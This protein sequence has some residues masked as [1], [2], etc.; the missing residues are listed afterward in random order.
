MKNLFIIF[1]F[2]SFCITTQAQNTEVVQKA[3][4]SGNASALTGQ[5]A[6]EIELCIGNDVQFLSAAQAVASL[7][8]WFA[9]VSPSSLSGKIVG[10]SAVKYYSGQL[11]TAKG[12]FRIFVYYNGQND[13]YKIDEIRIAGK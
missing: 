10:G 6:K 2:L 11:Q 7:N 3:F 8:K 12:D 4:E 5:L 1:S 9:S 13:A